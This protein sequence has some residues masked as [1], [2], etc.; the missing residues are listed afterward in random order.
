MKSTNDTSL[1]Q[2]YLDY[3][4]YNKRL[5]EKT[6]KAY[7]IDLRHFYMAFPDQPLISRTP[8]AI[9]AYI[10]SLH[11]LFKPRT[12]KRKIASIKAFYHHLEYR[13]IISITPFAKLQTR[14]REP[15]ILPKTIPLHTVEQLLAKIYTQHS[16]ASTP[17]QQM[18]TLRDAAII[19]LLFMTG[20]RISEL[21][22]LR[23]NS[24]NLH[25]G[26][27]LVYGKGDKERCLQITNPNVLSILSKYKSSV[28]FC[29]DPYAPFFV[30]Q[31]GTAVS[32]QSI[33]RMIR[34]YCKLANIN[35]HIT[36]H[37]FRH[38]FA[39]SLLDA[40]V[41]I[42]YIQEMLGHSSITTTEIYTHVSTAKQTD[43]LTNKHPRKDF[44]L[45]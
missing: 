37:M 12:V 5:D 10:S 3:C 14:F 32:D 26:T 6:V 21:C 20:F 45:V 18:H 19:E 1:I 22:S 2:T 34:K 44:R 16:N 29:P 39:T 35:L 4:K 42:R 31:N 41:D 13:D 9:E 24:I 27:I 15:L 30:N 23:N 38:T 8:Q 43:I 36:P 28:P 11:A 17:Y 25:T 40:D 7:A 33:R